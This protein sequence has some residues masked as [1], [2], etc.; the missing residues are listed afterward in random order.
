MESKIAKLLKLNNEPVAVIQSDA[1]PEKV[2]QFK[3]NRW[4]CAVAMLAAAANGK[5]A[6]FSRET[7]PC[8]G[9]RAG[10]GFE[11][12]PL[13][14]IEYFLSNGGAG[15]DRCERYK[16]SSDVAREFICGVS[17]A[18]IEKLPPRKKFLLLKPLSRVEDESPDAII[19]LVNA[20]QL[21]GL[22]TL[23]NYESPRAD[24][25]KILFGAGCAQ[26]I[27]YPLSEKNFCFV[28]L[29]D[30]SARKFLDK[31]LLAFSMAH[32]KFLR[33]ESLAEESFL[34]ADAWQKIFKRI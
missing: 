31:N 16:K 25:V 20:D 12:Y 27:L 29:T 28:G 14:W 32:E 11:K 1:C 3:E 10:L 19:F 23:A 6:A 24:A 26:T 9:G 18:L 13:G 15:V 7:T 4:G 8:L 33:L 22:V 30:P 2:L 17:N 34:T 21:S 5:I